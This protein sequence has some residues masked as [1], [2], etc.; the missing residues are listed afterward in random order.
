MNHIRIVSSFKIKWSNG[1]RRAICFEKV[2]RVWIQ[3]WICVLSERSLGQMI[4][5]I[6]CLIFLTITFIEVDGF[7]DDTIIHN[8][9]ICESGLSWHLFLHRKLPLWDIL[10]YQFW[11]LMSEWHTSL[12]SLSIIL[13]LLPL[14]ILDFRGR[15]LTTLFS[16]RAIDHGKVLLIHLLSLQES[17]RWDSIILLCVV[18]ISASSIKYGGELSYF[19]ESHQKL[20]YLVT[21][22]G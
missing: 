15:T 8:N 12:K 21:V 18:V 9:L 2:I 10:P 11:T 7:A 22:R 4:Y 6:G 19:L 16:L 3:S 20:L 1:L 17:F 5:V 13:K 14:L